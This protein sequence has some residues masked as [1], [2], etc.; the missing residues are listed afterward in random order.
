MPPVSAKCRSAFWQPVSSAPSK[1]QP[2]QSRRVADLQ[3]QGGIGWEVALLLAGMVV[4][5]TRQCKRPEPALHLETMAAP[6]P[7]AR[8]GRVG[9]LHSIHRPLQQAA[10]QRVGGLENGRADQPLQFLHQMAVRNLAGKTR[11]QLLDFLLLGQ[12]DLGR[13]VFFL[14]AAAIS[15]R[16]FCTIH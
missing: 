11:P 7:L 3:P 8:L 2:S 9:R 16:V 14:K 10:H 12:E 6:A 1:H 4:V 15:S 5:V 13:E